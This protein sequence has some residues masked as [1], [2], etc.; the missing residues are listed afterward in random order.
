MGWEN[1]QSIDYSTALS[2]TSGHENP[3]VEIA[4]PAIPLVKGRLIY[5]NGKP[6]H[7]GTI[8]IGTS[9]QTTYLNGHFTMAA[10]YGDPLDYQLGYAFDVRRHTGRMFFWRMADQ[11]EDLVLV[12]DWLCTVSGRII[13][14][15]GRP[16]SKVNIGLYAYSN[17]IPGQVHELWRQKR[18]NTEGF[19]VFNDVPVGVQMELVVN[20]IDAPESQ[21]QIDIG[22]LS[23]DQRYNTGDIV[24]TKSHDK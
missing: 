5:A 20:N 4:I 2:V 24:W 11:R 18:T 8:R 17:E 10:P 23:P 19:F 22:E 1:G 16:Q 3:S 15:K 12:L 7:K 21:T 13:D 9:K 14:Q 6:V